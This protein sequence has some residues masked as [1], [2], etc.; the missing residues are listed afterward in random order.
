M[1]KV[2]VPSEFKVG[3]NKRQ[4]TYNGKLGYMVYANKPDGSF[5]QQKSF[6]DWIDKS[7]P[8]E[9]LKNDY[10]L[11]FVLNK[12]M[13]NHYRFGA[14]ARFRVFHPHG[15]E[16]E[17]SLE[18]LSMLLAYTTISIGDINLPCRIGWMGKNCVLI[19]KIDLKKEFEIEEKNIGEKTEKQKEKEEMRKKSGKP[20][21]LRSL[22]DGRIVENKN[23]ERF[24]IHKPTHSKNVLKETYM[25]KEIGKDDLFGLMYQDGEKYERFFYPLNGA[26]GVSLKKEDLENFCNFVNLD[27][28]TE[29]EKKQYNYY[30][31]NV[32]PF[33]E[34]SFVFKNFDSDANE[35]K[36]LFMLG[37]KEARNYVQFMKKAANKTWGQ[38]VKKDNVAYLIASYQD[39]FDNNLHRYNKVGSQ[40]TSQFYLAGEKTF[41]YM[42]YSSNITLIPIINLETKDF[43][44]D[45]IVVSVGKE[46]KSLK[47]VVSVWDE[48]FDE[49]KKQFE[50]LTDE[51]LKLIQNSILVATDN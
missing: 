21:P 23:G 4:G 3:Y 37:K 33:F 29:K 39:I 47:T 34:K 25:Y 24:Y 19:P 42:L 45:H 46:K 22:I 14:S 11:G 15:F 49:F 40:K 6:D 36:N 2:I 32:T 44:K 50:P 20:I 43:V 17:I 9:T 41:D 35:F 16:F 38:V 28:L 13:L 7:M 1:E 10:M 12:G 51:E 31:Y 27:E 26:N 30:I 48:A 5:G 18:N 8:V